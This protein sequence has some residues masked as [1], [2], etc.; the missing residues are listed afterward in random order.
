MQHGKKRGDKR[1]KEGMRLRLSRA[2][3]R[4]PLHAERA[5][6]GHLPRCAM[7]QPSGRQGVAPA[8][9][10]GAL[11]MG[12][13]RPRAYWRR[14]G[15]DDDAADGCEREPWAGVAGDTDGDECWR[16]RRKARADAA[17]DARRRRRDALCAHGVLGGRGYRCCVER[18]L[19]TAP[20]GK[21]S[22]FCITCGCF[23]GFIF[24]PLHFLSFSSPPFFSVGSSLLDGCC[25]EQRLVTTPSS[26]ANPHLDPEQS[27]QPSTPHTHTLKEDLCRRS[28]TTRRT[29]CP[30]TAPTH[31]KDYL[32]RRSR[33]T[34]RT[35]CPTTPHTHTKDDLCRRSRTT[36]RTICPT[37]NRLYSRRSSSRRCLLGIRSSCS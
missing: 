7:W 21:S 13:T 26:Q 33:T 8:R 1:G 37:T 5:G 4:D 23:C 20:S 19:V 22:F 29:I 31:T 17:A 35:I 18:H 36:R 11:G 25:V 30:T 27:L 15:A 24:V 28:R 16:V 12:T 14:G 9:R 3:P 2:L 10:L 34:R 6:R 32:C